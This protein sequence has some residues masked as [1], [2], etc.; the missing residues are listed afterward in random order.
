MFGES[1][2]KRKMS[3][4]IE[5]KK[6]MESIK[7]ILKKYDIASSIVLVSHNNSEFLYELPTWSAMQWNDDGKSMKI[8]SKKNDFKTS[9]QQRINLEQSV[10]I[11]AQNRDIAAQSFEMFQ[12]VYETLEKHIEIKHKSY[13]GFE[14]H[15][16]EML[17]K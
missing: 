13:S 10:H 3:Y 11:I 16:D 6:A 17:K 15:R 12:K 2:V 14:P 8:K 9:D 7:A 5:L 4:D 1:I